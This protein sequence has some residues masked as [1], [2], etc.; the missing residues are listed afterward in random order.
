MI[1]QVDGWWHSGGAGQVVHHHRLDRFGAARGRQLRPVPLRRLL[2]EP[3]DGSPSA[4]A[5]ARHGGVHGAGAA[6]GRGVHP[7]HHRP[8]AHAPRH[9]ADRDTVQA[10]RRRGVPRPARHA[11]VDVGH[12]DGGVPAVR[13]PSRRDRGAHRGDEP[14][15]RDPRHRN[16]TDPTRLPYT[17]LSP[18]A[19][20]PPTATTS[21]FRGR[22]SSPATTLPS[23]DLPQRLPSHQILAP[24]DLPRRGEPIPLVS[25]LF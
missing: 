19:P 11:G 12:S 20:T 21:Y 16:R 25:P 24:P 4:D 13:R 7:H 8:A 22:S 2:A 10:L 23:V 17:L 14:G 18:K 15:Y 1:G 9:L 5:G 3:A 6:P